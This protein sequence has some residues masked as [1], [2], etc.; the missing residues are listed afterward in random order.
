[1]NSEQVLIRSW[2]G[3]LLCKPIFYF[4]YAPFLLLHNRA[5]PRGNRHGASLTQQSPKTVMNARLEGH[6]KG[7]IRVKKG[8]RDMQVKI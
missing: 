7:P 8:S 6:L 1:M 5:L 4:N 3:F 2:R